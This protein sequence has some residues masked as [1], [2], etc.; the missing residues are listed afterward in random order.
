[1]PDQARARAGLSWGEA[2]GEAEGGIGLRGEAQADGIEGLTDG[3]AKLR[4]GRDLRLVEARARRPADGP[5]RAHAPETRAGG[6]VG[7][8]C[9]TQGLAGSGSERAA[10]WGS[11]AAAGLRHAVPCAFLEQCRD[12]RPSPVQSARSKAGTCRH[13]A[14]SHRPAAG[15]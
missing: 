8:P 10:L 14:L 11:H 3:A 5:R 2:V 1:M 12:V 7:A 9:R 4:F 15:V 13:S 6:G